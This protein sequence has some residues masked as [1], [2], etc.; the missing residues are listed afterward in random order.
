MQRI[1]DDIVGGNGLAGAL[2]PLDDP[3]RPK[4][5][6]LDKHAITRGHLNMC[7]CDPLGRQREFGLQAQKYYEEI[8]ITRALEILND[9]NDSSPSFTL[10]FFGSGGL[11]Q[12]EIATT[13]LL[14]A[15]SERS[16]PLARINLVFVDTAY[17]LDNKK[18][19]P[20]EMRLAQFKQELGQ[21]RKVASLDNQTQIKY[22]AYPSAQDYI[23]DI[24]KGEALRHDLMVAC[25][26]LIFT[27]ANSKPTPCKADACKILEKTSLNGRPGIVLKKVQPQ[28][29][30][31]SF[32]RIVELTSEQNENI[33]HQIVVPEDPTSDDHSNGG[34]TP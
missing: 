14:K 10:V 29:S 11:L 3:N 6:G 5:Q 22:Y 23:Q 30:K 19:E 18:H 15:L 34:V 12:E 8:I 13:K 9:K 24:E 25:D 21:L 17:A 16:I 7:S 28:G 20:L 27:Q 33:I 4:T 1:F 26:V 31:D 32:L 2:L